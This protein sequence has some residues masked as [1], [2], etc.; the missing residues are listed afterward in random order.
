VA[1]GLLHWAVVVAALAPSAPA[2]AH[3]E[4]IFGPQSS[5][6]LS[7]PAFLSAQSYSRALAQPGSGETNLVLSGGLTPRA[8]V[9]LSLTAILTGSRL[10]SGDAPQYGVENVILGAR[11]RFD[12]QGLIDRFHRDGN[13]LLA[14][15]A[16]EPPTGNVEHAAFHGPWNGMGALLASVEVG[17]LSGIAYA[18]GRHHGTS[19]VGD[20]VG[21]DLF[22]GGG[23]AWTP[24][25]D[26]ARGRLFS[27]QL[28]YSHEEYA[29]NTLAGMRVPES[30]G[31]MDIVHP[32]VVAGFAHHWLAFAVVSIP[33]SAEMRA[34]AQRDLW[35]AGGGLVYLFGG[36]S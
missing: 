32:T 35:R 24:L 29:R 2:Q 14:M 4:A 23:V 12:L 26:A 30:G 5:L 34:D 25:D 31:R 27:L 7:A 1:R 13:F 17:P 6:V 8:R 11:Y 9:P 10:T 36:E 19:A 18:F 16:V 20:H 21:D 22:L 28:G 3:H 33:V 15:A